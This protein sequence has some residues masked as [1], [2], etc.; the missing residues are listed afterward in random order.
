MPE[1]QFSSF[2]DFLIMGGHAFYVWLAYLAFLAFLL[3]NIIPPIFIQKRVIRQTKR[4]LDSP[5]DNTPISH[6]GE[7]PNDKF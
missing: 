6:Y 2:H 4:F 5:M 3:F 1:F 7:T